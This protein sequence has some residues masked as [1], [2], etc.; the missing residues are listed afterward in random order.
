MARQAVYEEFFSGKNVWRKKYVI[1]E[2]YAKLSFIK[3]YLLYDLGLTVFNC[4]FLSLE[5]LAEL[6]I[7]PVLNQEQST[8][9]FANDVELATLINQLIAKHDFAYFR[10]EVNTV[11]LSREVLKM[12]KQCRLSELK[13]VDGKGNELQEFLTILKEYQEQLSVN[14]YFDYRAKLDVALSNLDFF[15]KEQP[16][17]A[18]FDDH[19]LSLI[20]QKLKQGLKEKY[21]FFSLPLY[22]KKAN[23]ASKNINFYQVRSKRNEVLNVFKIMVDNDYAPDSV[24]ICYTDS[25]YANII[26]SMAEFFNLKI[27]FNA[28]IAFHNSQVYELLNTICLYLSDD[29]KVIHFK[30]IYDK[31]L[32]ANSYSVEDSEINT[33][34]IT[35]VKKL[36]EKA[37]LKPTDVVVFG[38]EQVELIK[39]FC[40]D[41]VAVFAGKTWL[42]KIIA[43][44][45]LNRLV[46]FIKQYF[47]IKSSAASREYGVLEKIDNFAILVEKQAM[48]MYT[49]FEQLFAYLDSFSFTYNDD[50][51]QLEN[52][53][54]VRALSEKRPIIRKNAFVLGMNSH[55]FAKQM[56]ETPVLYDDFIESVFIDLKTS[57]QKNETLKEIIESNINYCQSN[58]LYLSYNAYDIKENIA[59]T[60]VEFFEQSRADLKA[61]LV[62][63]EYDF[64]Q[65]ENSLNL[66][67]EVLKIRDYDLETYFNVE[68]TEDGYICQCLQRDNYIE[69]TGMSEKCSATKL[70]DFLVNP[71]DMFFDSILKMRDYDEEKKVKA[72]QWLHVIERG[73]LVHKILEQCFDPNFAGHLDLRADYQSQFEQIFE[74]NCAEYLKEFPPLHLSIYQKEKRLIKELLFSYLAEMATEEREILGCEL[75]F[76]NTTRERLDDEVFPAIEL[77]FGN[78]AVLLENDEKYL[79]S[80]AGNEIKIKL[81]GSIDRLEKQGDKLI[82]VDYKTGNYDKF[83]SYKALQGY[84]YEQAIRTNPSAFG[85]TKE[86]VRSMA[87]EYHFVF[88]DIYAKELES[89]TS[90]YCCDSV[91]LDN[92]IEVKDISKS[93]IKVVDISLYARLLELLL[94]L[95]NNLGFSDSIVEV[96]SLLL[97]LNVWSNRWKYSLNHSLKNVWEVE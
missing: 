5:Q 95:V 24:E 15:A 59:L 32:F 97:N 37:Y 35:F 51:E 17:F 85:L 94:Q 58:N 84:I 68:E 80:I 53:I 45:F 82:I 41:F 88:L 31:L 63:L 47:K 70:N 92:K 23:L 20:E 27:A 3:Q 67:D 16:I 81:S 18:F 62:E 56:A 89:V 21:E 93:K 78:V 43:S 96:L 12:I 29:Y 66:V 74:T 34:L 14:N 36:S 2:D 50:K 7:M 71:L 79:Q 54:L 46:A 10:D 9:H 60:P 65:E 33:D 22:D 69:K 39:Q 73:N 87:I 52:A 26:M 11:K 49:I 42:D 4:R 57:K 13:R 83:K 77:S 40:L 61:D 44:D 19:D 38:S 1:V 48:P 86:E 6:M 55:N 75:S 76:G 72:G 64:K 28:G 90:R 30:K 8:F 91:V 25:E